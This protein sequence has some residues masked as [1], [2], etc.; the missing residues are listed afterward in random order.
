MKRRAVL[1]GFTVLYLSVAL[2]AQRAQEVYQRGLSQEHAA[3]DLEDAI[4]LYRQAAQ[5]AG[6]DRQLAARSLNRA[7][8]AYEKLGRDA[9]AAGLYADVVRMYP[10][11]RTEAGVARQRLAALRQPPAGTAAGGVGLTDVSAVTVP[12][13][14]RYCR[15]CHNAGN[16]AGGLDLTAL[17]QRNVATSTTTWEKVLRRLVARHDPPAGSVRPDEATVRSV[18]VR[19]QRALDA[20]Y[21]ATHLPATAERIDDGELAVRLAK[22]IWS[23]APDASLLEEAAA[24]RLHQPAVLDRQVARMLRDRKSAHL[25]DGFFTEWLSLDRI[26]TVR[27]DPVRF[28]AVDG[29]LVAAMATE[30][31]LFVDEQLRQDH[32]ALELWTADYTYVNA[33]LARHYGVPGVSGKEFKRITWSDSRRAGL[34]GQAGILAAWSMSTRT[35]PTQRG[36]FVL[37]RYFGVDPPSPPANVPALAE[38]PAS[39]ATMRD[40]LR[41]HKVNPSCTSCHA[42]FDPIGLAL[43]NF[44]A[45]GEWRATDGGSPIDASGMFPDGTRF[46]GPAGLRTGLL[47]Y[48]DAYYTAVTQRLLAYALNRGKAGQVYDHEMP[49]VRSIVRHAAAEGHRWSAIL[50]GIAASTPFQLKQVVP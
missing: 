23:A 46:D 45:T 33:R 25:L 35:S 47:A 38:R 3:G 36:R 22:F 44:D 50:A 26:R 18:I 20:G 13:F 1:V 4:T 42:M 49:A 24:G 43:E 15:G 28:P 17:D 11:Q 40:R 14:E 48:R 8:G 19:L 10:E 27:P 21:S 2:M 9:D 7:A 41:I 31:R 30:T 5:M 29:D 32:D 37:S 6:A 12:F 34:L 16:K 39:A